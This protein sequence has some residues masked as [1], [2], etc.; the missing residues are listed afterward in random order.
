MSKHCYSSAIKSLLVYPP[1]REINDDIK[2]AILLRKEKD[3]QTDFYRKLQ[4]LN[5]R[6]HAYKQLFLANKPKILDFRYKEGNKRR[7]IAYRKY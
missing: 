4:T 1:F 3:K 6:I 2:H 5:D 7:T